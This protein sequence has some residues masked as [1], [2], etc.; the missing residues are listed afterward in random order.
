MRKA[1]RDAG[2]SDEDFIVEVD[3]DT[4]FTDNKKIKSTSTPSSILHYYQ[5]RRKDSIP[6]LKDESKI[7][8]L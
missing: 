3:G 4:N 7:E 1:F 8:N 5:D 2:F 6:L